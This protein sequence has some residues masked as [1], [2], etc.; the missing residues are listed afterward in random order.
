[1]AGSC[2]RRRWEACGHG[3]SAA[4]GARGVGGMSGCADGADAACE[5]R[6]WVAGVLAGIRTHGMS[7]RLVSAT[8]AN[9]G[10]S[11]PVA[12]LLMDPTP[13]RDERERGRGS[14]DPVGAHS[15]N[16]SSTSHG[17][18][19]PGG[20]GAR[21]WGRGSLRPRRVAPRYGIDW[22]ALRDLIYRGSAGE[23]SD[24]RLHLIPR[25]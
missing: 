9:A 12:P 11:P 24:R 8:K 21:A 22:A 15:D 18:V 19:G 16:V 13:A 10:L 14:S 7:A 6:G 20:I 25:L 4:A 5:C 2:G 17:T 1:M 3:V 23:L